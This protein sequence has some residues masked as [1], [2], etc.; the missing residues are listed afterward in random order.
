MYTPVQNWK[1]RTTWGQGFRAPSFMERFID[2]NHVQFGYQVIGNPNL[3]P[4]SSNGYTAGVEYY[5]PNHYHISL[6][7]Y[8]TEFENLIQDYAIEP[9]LLSYHNISN[10]EYKGIEIQGQW[11]ISNTWIA[12][13]GLNIIDNRDEN[14]TMISNTQPLSSNFRISY[15]QPFNLWTLSTQIKWVDTFT[16]NEY[17]P[18]S[19]TYISSEKFDAHYIIDINGKIKIWDSITLGSGIKNISDYTNKKFGPFIG[20]SFYMELTTNIKGV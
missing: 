8:Y 1:F 17:D 11:N 20:R 4:E 10:A 15:Q 12:S 13:W 16:P 6:M 2:W 3:K 18:Q 14:G 9:A 7:L 5:H 19:G